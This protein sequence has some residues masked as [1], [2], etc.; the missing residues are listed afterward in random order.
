MTAVVW[1]CFLWLFITVIVV[2]LVIP[3]IPLLFKCQTHCWSLLIP[4]LLCSNWDIEHSMGSYHHTYWQNS[5]PFFPP[6]QWEVQFQNLS[7]SVC[8]LGALLVSI[9]LVWVPH[10]ADFETRLWGCIVNLGVI[11]GNTSM[12]VRRWDRKG[13]RV[14][15]VYVNNHRSPLWAMGDGVEH[16]SEL[17]QSHQR[18]HVAGVFVYQLLF[19]TGPDYPQGARSSAFWPVLRVSWACSHSQRKPLGGESPGLEVRSCCVHGT[20]IVK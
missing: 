7:L 12:E 5:D 11:P 10:K 2:I 9:I 15:I 17:S 20:V 14:H 19:I 18:G 3:I 6:G 16:A 13:K 4:F 1:A 8:S